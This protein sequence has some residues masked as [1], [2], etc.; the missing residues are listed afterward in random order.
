MIGNNLAIYDIVIGNWSQDD[1]Q[2]LSAVMDGNWSMCP[3]PDQM[4]LLW[5]VSGSMGMQFNSGHN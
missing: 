4:Q 1:L 2:Q 5:L 3:P